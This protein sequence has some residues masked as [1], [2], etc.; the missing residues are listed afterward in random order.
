MN[1]Y[2]AEMQEKVYPPSLSEHEEHECG[3]ACGCCGL[4]MI[5][6]DVEADIDAFLLQHR[7]CSEAQL[8]FAVS[9]AEHDEDVFLA[10]TKLTPTDA[11]QPS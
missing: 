6:V 5:P 1:L 2:P 10:T 7:K 9:Q 8:V 3:L 4:V 11:P